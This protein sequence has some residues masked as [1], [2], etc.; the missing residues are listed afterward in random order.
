MESFAK[1]KKSISLKKKPNGQ[2][3]TQALGLT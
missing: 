2:K 3:A 1:L